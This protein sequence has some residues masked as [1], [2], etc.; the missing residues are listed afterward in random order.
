M[1]RWMCGVKLNGEGELRG[2]MTNPDSPDEDFG[3]VKCVKVKV[4]CAILLLEFRRDTHL[5]S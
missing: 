1:I 3:G 5:P 4:K 2:Q